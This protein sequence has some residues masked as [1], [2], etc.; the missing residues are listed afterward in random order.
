MYER[1]IGMLKAH[2]VEYKVEAE[3]SAYTSVKI[4]GVAGLIILPDTA[5]KMIFTVDCL[6][7]EGYTFKV[8]GRMTNILAPDGRVDIP[9][10]TTRRLLGFSL[11][12]EGIVTAASGEGIMRILH[13][14]AERD[15]GGCEML[16]G[17][18]GTIGGLVAMNAGAF[19]AEISDF[20]IGAHAYDIKHRKSVRLSRGDMRF[21]Y[22]SSVLRGSPLV[23]LSVDL[24]LQRKPMDAVVSDIER[25]KKIR[26]D[27]Q[28][29]EPSLG[30]VFMRSDGVIPARLID[31]LGL[32]GYRV[33]GAVVSEKHVGF[34]INRGGATA[35]DFRTLVDYIKREVYL[36]LGVTIREEVEYL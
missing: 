18:P 6:L 20:F 32:R 19:G 25:Y 36:K 16:S 24:A 10:I 17:I 21:A 11:S 8:V 3:L 2:D 34:I 13:Y 35:V 30:S 4:G 23:L 28:P 26:L 33:G 22:R 12:E 7:D 31:S 29:T 9:L 14:S 1:L 15:F 5:N 27:T